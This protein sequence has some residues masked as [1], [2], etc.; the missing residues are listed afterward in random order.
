MSKHFHKELDELREN[1]LEQGKR[2]EQAIT[3]AIEAMLNRDEDLAREVIEN[4]RAIDEAEIEIEEECLKLLALYQPIAGDLR[5]MMSA[6]KINNDLERI[7]D[8]AANICERVIY[9]S[10]HN[11]L[12]LRERFEKMTGQVQE[13]IRTSLSALIERDEEKAATV[14]AMDDDVDRYHEE[15]FQLLSEKI[16][17]DPE[18]T[19][20]AFQNLSASRYLERIADHA[21]NIAEDVIYMERGEIVRHQNAE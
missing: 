6:L 20:V 17:S 19:E 10:S 8:L 21:T 2:V 16:Q 14:P 11:K 18:V 5:F 3:G 15:M 12:D 7:A 1:L 4:D 13:M 9:I